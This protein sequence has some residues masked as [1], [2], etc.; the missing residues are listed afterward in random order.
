MTMRTFLPADRESVA[1]G[2]QVRAAAERRNSKMRRDDMAALR[3]AYESQNEWLWQLADQLMDMLESGAPWP[4][5]AQ[6]REAI[7]E[8]ASR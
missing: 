4:Q 6:V 3:R 8:E 7:F 1:F 5:R 2:D